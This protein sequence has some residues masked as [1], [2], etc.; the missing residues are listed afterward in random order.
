MRGLYYRALG[1]TNLSLGREGVEERRRL[2]LTRIRMGSFGRGS[3]KSGDWAGS[4]HGKKGY[5]MFG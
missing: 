5:V 1:V 2:K 3:S 4:L